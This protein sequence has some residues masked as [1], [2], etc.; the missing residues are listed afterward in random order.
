MKFNYKPGNYIKSSNNTSRIIRKISLLILFLYVWVILFYP[1]NNLLLYILNTFIICSFNILINFL[2][3]KF[4]RNKKS[5]LYIIGNTYSFI[6][7]LLI[8]M[9]LPVNMPLIGTLVL[10]L[11]VFLIVLLV[12]KFFN[13]KLNYIVMLLLC[14]YIYLN[15][16]NVE[17][18]YIL[19]LKN[20]TSLFLIL[21][22]IIIAAFL[23]INDCI[24]WRIT[25]TYFIILIGCMLL[26]T[27]LNRNNYM[28]FYLNNIVSLFNIIYA[29][30]VINEFKSTSIIPFTQYVY[31]FFSAI[32]MFIGFKLDNYYLAFITIIFFNILNLLLDNIYINLKNKN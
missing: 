19:L 23:V 8:S 27:I 25:I 31:A 12:N 5:L 32:T 22:T 28:N 17:M 2:Y 1:I 13:I 20:S 30:F 29:L 9:L 21:I 14:S 6:N 15:I 3:Y 18:N 16:N 11:I 24:K 4:T 10:M 26:D 7:G